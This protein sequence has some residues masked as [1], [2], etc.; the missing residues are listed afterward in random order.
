MKTLKKKLIN[1]KGGGPIVKLN[2]QMINDIAKPSDIACKTRLDCS[3][4]ALY[5]LG[6]SDNAFKRLLSKFVKNLKKLKKNH[7][8]KIS[9][10][11][12]IIR[13]YENYIRKNKKY[14]IEEDL[15]PTE[16][17]YYRW[18]R[19]E[20]LDDKQYKEWIKRIVNDIFKTIP[21]GYVSIVFL[22]SPLY[23]GGHYINIGKTIDGKEF[24]LDIQNNVFVI[25]NEKKIPIYDYFFKHKIIY[26]SSFIKG[27]KIKSVENTK[28]TY[29]A[30]RHQTSKKKFKSY[31]S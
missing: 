7:G 19:L 13:Q 3:L 29:N 12:E 11:V 18:S 4:I 16:P 27:L 9:E 8:I 15:G 1:L 10:I 24:L 30:H 28:L 25:T 22:E 2:R 23:G 14:I 17:D 31:I 21:N 6:V 5:F 20:L 26:V